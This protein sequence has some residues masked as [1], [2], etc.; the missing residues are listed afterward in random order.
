MGLDPNHKDEHKVTQIFLMLKLSF[1]RCG[2][3]LLQTS[4][5]AYPT[6]MGGPS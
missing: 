3:R 6:I 1:T 2:V 5:L 4:F